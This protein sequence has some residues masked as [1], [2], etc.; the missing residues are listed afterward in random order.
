MHKKVRNIQIANLNFSKSVTK[1]FKQ[2][3]CQ[4]NDHN[5]HF[6]YLHKTEF[7]FIAISQRKKKC[8]SR[9]TKHGTQKIRSKSLY[10]MEYTTL[11]VPLSQRDQ[12]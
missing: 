10:L 12:Y 1:C 11:F 5:I 4:S 8:K 3:I 7:I 2:S 9:F 6:Y